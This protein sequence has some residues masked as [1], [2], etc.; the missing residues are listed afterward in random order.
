M[1]FL[2]GFSGLL[3][4]RHLV[5]KVV[6]L[7]VLI[8]AFFSIQ[9]AHGATGVY[10]F[11]PNLST[12]TK[13]GGIAGIRKTFFVD[14]RF[15]LSVEG[16]T[17]VFERVDAT[18][19]DEVGAVYLQSLDEVFNMTALEADVVDVN[20]IEFKGKTADGTGSD[21]SITLTFEE[22]L[23]RLKGG[24]TPPPD[25]A[26]LFLY[27]L[28]AV[29]AR[30]YAAGTGEPNDPYQIAT[31]ADLISLGETTEDYEKHFIMTADIDLDPNLPGRKIFDKAVISTLTG[32]F[33]GNGHTISH[34]AIEGG[35]YLG[36][37]GDLRSG[38]KVLNLGIANVSITASDDYAG[39]CVGVNGGTLTGCYSTGVV[40]GRE[41][42]GGLVGDNWGI[43]VQCYSICE[44]SGG[45]G[46]GGLMG[47]NS[48]GTVS[49]CY[50][51][52]PVHGLGQNTGLLAYNLGTVTSCFWDI[53][54][55]GQAESAGGAGKATTEM[56]TANTFLDAGWDFVGETS[57]GAEDIWW[58]D[59]GKSYPRL[60]W[61]PRKYGGG[62]GEPNDPYLI[63][64]AEQMNDIGAEPNDWDKHF[65]LMSNIDLSGYL[66]SAALIA[67]DNDPDDPAFQGIPFK[68]T[69]DGNGRTISHLTI[70][71]AGF[72]G[73]I[74]RLDPQA[75]VENLKLMDVNL[76]GLDYVGALAGF[77]NGL[78]TK[79][80]VTGT[81]SG[82]D[83]VG[84]LTGRNWGR[85]TASYNAASVTGN[86][87][88]GGITA[89]NY[90]T[91]TNCYNTGAV[92]AARDVGGIV[93]ENYK[94]I[95]MTYSTG[96]VSGTDRAGGLVGY[97]WQEATA[98]ITASFWDIET[99][100][101]TTS[102]GGIGKTTTEMQ[103]AKTFT[104]AGWDFA[105][106]TANG[107][108]DIWTIEGGQG[109]PRLWWE[110][111]PLLN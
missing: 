69:I 65:K 12:V 1:T 46:I 81:I 106:E 17:A 82:R 96:P 43:V 6:M 97:N 49:N 36:L 105:G 80:C 41:D 2:S 15:Q 94:S 9:S 58:I 70:H 110:L 19:T 104:D 87:D 92:T 51:A 52:G 68:G 28:G 98:T 39:G 72:I 5:T 102:D 57:N 38:A 11:D 64:T 40:S 35:G 71:G 50:S 14:G 74:G 8:T 85:V 63:Y 54:T 84:G 25:T 109:Y 91:I 103:S 86:S 56:Q 67:P 47:E 21:V 78:I 3:Q 90:N 55:S 29:A 77:N 53:E 34:L 44:V 37:F 75:A 76:A 99:S 30:K 111:I 62:S 10:V 89:A 93:G 61:E 108:E 79:S 88:V 107:T 60:W 20:K 66:Y 83:R 73:L 95:S 13:T 59:E 16:N 26:D 45:Y 4:K 48:S 42:A 101:Q 24:T 27:D 31:A 22:D 33:D 100:T 32:S 7:P 18:L 23:V